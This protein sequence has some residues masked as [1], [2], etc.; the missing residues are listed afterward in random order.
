GGVKMN[1]DIIKM[2]KFILKND[3]LIESFYKLVF[4]KLIKDKYVS[5]N[6]ILKKLTKK[7]YATNSSV[8]IEIRRILTERRIENVETL[9][10]RLQKLEE[11]LIVQELNVRDMEALITIV[12]SYFSLL[13]HKRLLLAELAGAELRKDKEIL[14]Q[15]LFSDETSLWKNNLS[16]FIKLKFKYQLPKADDDDYITLRSDKNFVENQVKAVVG[17]INFDD[18]G[19]SSESVYKKILEKF[20]ADRVAMTS[21]KLVLDSRSNYLFFDNQIEIRS[22]ETLED[23]RKVIEEIDYAN[24]NSESTDDISNYILPKKKKLKGKNLYYRGHTNVNYLLEPSIHR[25][26][27]F[28]NEKLLCEESQIRNPAE[29]ENCA[30]HLDRLKKMQHYNIPTRLLDISRNALMGLYFAVEKSGANDDLEGEVIVFHESQP[31][32]TR[33]DTIAL[34][35]SIAFFDMI[36]KTKMALYAS[37]FIDYSMEEFNADEDVERLVHEI[38]SEKA[39]FLPKIVRSDLRSNYIVLPTKDNKRIIQQDG[40]FIACALNMFDAED[41]NQL[42]AGQNKK[43][44]LTIKSSNKDTLRE[45]LNLFGLNKATVYPE[46]DKVAEYLKEEYID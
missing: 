36:F 42:R 1:D 11:D 39:S 6:Y 29:Y 9:K 16:P 22:I 3:F 23:Y 20:K 19:L 41:I 46:I 2:R 5:L 24:Q 43:V 31:R 13:D 12:F 7:H 28:K 35:C 10:S 38:Q 21:E 15:K 8:K 32:Y 34:I 14:I 33:S 17:R 26:N 45:T 40:A 4:E 30:T 25:G 27:F 18:E 44:I 37:R